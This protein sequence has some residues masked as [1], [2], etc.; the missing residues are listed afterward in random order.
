MKSIRMNANITKTSINGSKFNLNINNVSPSTDMYFEVT[1]NNIKRTLENILRTENVMTGKK[2]TPDKTFKV[3][4]NLTN[5]WASE[6]LRRLNDKNFT[7]NSV[8]LSSLFILPSGF[9]EIY[10]NLE[11]YIEPSKA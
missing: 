6:V 4:D 1:G 3:L 9:D 11:W 2:I 5:K 7:G 10:V 8:S